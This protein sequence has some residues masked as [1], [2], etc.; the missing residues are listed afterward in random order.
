MLINFWTSAHLGN[1]IIAIIVIACCVVVS[2]VILVAVCAKR[3]MRKRCPR[4]HRHQVPPFHQPAVGDIATIS[5]GATNSNGHILGRSVTLAPFVTAT[6]QRNGDNRDNMAY[7]PDAFRDRMLWD[8]GGGDGEE[9]PP[10]YNSVIGRDNHGGSG[11]HSDRSRRRLLLQ[12]GTSADRLENG[13]AST[14]AGARTQ[15]PAGTPTTTGFAR[16][17][18]NYRSLPPTPVHAP[19]VP[20]LFVALLQQRGEAAV[21]DSAGGGGG[22]RDSMSEHIYEEP[23]LLFGYGASPMSDGIGGFDYAPSSAARSAAVSPTLPNMRTASRIRLGTTALHGGRTGSTIDRRY[24]QT[25]SS[26]SGRSPDD[27]CFG[28][29]DF[30][31]LAD[32]Q[33][34]GSLRGSFDANGSASSTAI[35][36]DDFTSVHETAHPSDNQ[37]YFP[38]SSNGNRFYGC[39]ATELRQPRHGDLLP[40][41][42]AKSAR[43][44]TVGAPNCYNPAASQTQHRAG[45]ARQTQPRSLAC[46]SPAEF[47]AHQNVASASPGFNSNTFHQ[48]APPSSHEPCSSPFDAMPYHR[49]DR[50]NAA[51]PNPSVGGD[52]PPTA[53]FHPRMNSTESYGNSSLSPLVLDPYDPSRRSDI[54]FLSPTCV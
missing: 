37:S 21:C 39:S 38:L 33:S 8:R 51:M 16:D 52:A 34:P 31:M 50:S 25:P 27:V 1:D 40:D 42:G 35:P 17:R 53:H 32:R 54:K 13:S 20:P 14:A 15:T 23:S 46:H 49:S 47:Y 18:Q 45:G 30:Q 7:V 29:A 43:G 22:V 48:R 19:A 4:R 26:C 9:P 10:P 6:Q 5:T 41:N 24:N 36:L 12:R 2:I 3:R 44:G 11:R 28:D